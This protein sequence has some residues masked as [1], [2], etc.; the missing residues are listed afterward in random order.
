[1]TY[2]I[3]VTTGTFSSASNVSSTSRYHDSTS[4]TL[5]NGKVLVFGNHELSG[6]TTT[7]VYD[8]EIQTLVADL[9]RAS[10]LQTEKY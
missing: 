3:T 9:R 10:F 2:T 8:R 5:S 7:D 1:M 4:I 6:T